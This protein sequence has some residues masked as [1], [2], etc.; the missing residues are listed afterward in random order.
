M[1]DEFVTETNSPYGCNET[2]SI[3]YICVPRVHHECKY[4]IGVTLCIDIYT[5]PYICIL[6]SL[7][8]RKTFGGFSIIVVCGEIPFFSSLHVIRKGDLKH[9]KRKTSEARLKFREQINVMFL[10]NLLWVRR[11]MSITAHPGII[12]IIILAP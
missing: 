11:T 6:F 8:H 3:R 5:H 12:I 10:W 2:V 9:Y 1:N 4:R 7:A